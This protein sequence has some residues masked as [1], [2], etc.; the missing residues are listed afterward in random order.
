MALIEDDIKI[1]ITRLITEYFRTNSRPV[2]LA[3]LQA[4]L[5]ADIV[6]DYPSGRFNGVA[7]YIQHQSSTARFL[8]WCCF[9][10]DV[11]ASS[12]IEF[13]DSKGKKQDQNVAIPVECEIA[14]SI[15]WEYRSKALLCCCCEIRKA[16]VNW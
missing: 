5:S 3:G 10:S 14:C 11:K 12:E 7:D 9:Y 8:Q 15:N 2:D 16:G 6:V 4:I 1:T 13:F